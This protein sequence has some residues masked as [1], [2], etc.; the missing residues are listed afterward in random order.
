MRTDTH[1]P[2]QTPDPKIEAVEGAGHAPAYRGLV[3]IVFEDL[4][5][6]EYGNRVP[7]LT[8]WMVRVKHGNKVEVFDGTLSKIKSQSQEYVLDFDDE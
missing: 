7:V 4:P 6:A 2:G 5:L 1:H 3:Y 8:H